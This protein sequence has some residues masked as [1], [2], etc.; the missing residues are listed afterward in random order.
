M[1][2]G[3]W[4]VAALGAALL[5]LLSTD[6]PFDMAD[7]AA[8]G[9][10]ILDGQ[11]SGVYADG[12]TQ[13]GPVQLVITW[14]LMIGGSTGVPAAA[15]RV[16]V[17]T[18]LTLGAMA[19][20]RRFGTGRGPVAALRESATGLLVILWLAGP[21]PWD[22]HPAELLV[23]LLWTYAIVCQSRKRTGTAAALLG[24][25]VAIAPWA[26][27][28]FP[29]LLAV[30]G[31]RAALRTWVLGGTVGVAF[32][33]PFV[34]AGNFHMFGHVWPVDD[35]TLI[36]LLLPGLTTVTW[37]LRLV[38]AVLVAGACAAVAWFFRRQRIVW[39]AA[40]AA[41]S[42]TR[43]FTD[44][45]SLRY[46]WTPI[47]VATVLVFALL[48]DDERPRRQMFALLLGYLVVL[49]GLS[50][51]QV[52]GAAAGLVALVALLVAGE[53]RRPAVPVP[54]DTVV[55]PAA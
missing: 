1:L 26:I 12:W 17:N 21:V 48:G 43:L 9:R 13:A 8:Y 36:G 50:T 47:A 30:A 39:A 27:L 24:V 55:T 28:G 44:P 23:P 45:V 37:P 14:L 29:G 15:A 4:V 19:L 6:M 20:C 35:D 22:G 49:G 10:Q 51:R 53:I 46:Y 5:A 32:Y 18:G 7:F 34:L 40:P 16:A 38:Q 2:R 25:S 3:R 42:L 31:P 54:G 52:P 33:L 11:L 41:A